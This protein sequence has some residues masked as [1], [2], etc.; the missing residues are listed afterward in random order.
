MTERTEA[1]LTL[2]CEAPSWGG[3]RTA[4]IGA[5]TFADSESGAAALRTACAQL[6]A[7]GY[8]TVIGPMAGSTWGRYRLPIASDGS[9][10]FALEPTAGPHDL[11]AWQAAGFLL[12]EEHS[13]ATAPPGVPATARTGAERGSDRAAL[14]ITSWN[15]VD[16]AS[17]LTDAHGLVMDG[18]A[19][20]PFFTPLPAATFVAAYLPLVQRTDPRFIM[21]ACDRSGRTVG[22]TLAF[23]DPMRTGAVVLKTCVGHIPGAGRAMAAQVHR[24][25][26]ELGFREVIH[27]LMRAGNV[28]LALSRKFG[29]HTFRRYALLGLVL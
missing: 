29:G 18:F 9:P 28:S 11:A 21:R 19:D 10:P 22:L 2:Y 24:L 8:E 25:A 26:G 6:K 23:P 13:S 17:L 7:K 27:A 14:T 5:A 3:R 4:A 16:A 12:I 1:S 20:T 15:G